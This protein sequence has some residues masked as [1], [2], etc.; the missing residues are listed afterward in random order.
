MSTT[1]SPLNITEMAAGELYPHSTFNAAMAILNRGGRVDEAVANE[2]SI[3]TTATLDATAFGKTHIITGTSADYT[4]TLFT[5]VT[6]DLGKIIGFRVSNAATKVFTIDA[7]GAETIDGSTSL[8]LVKNEVVYLKAV[9]TTGNTWQVIGRNTSSAIVWT[10]AWTNLT[11]GNGTVV[12]SF[13]KIGK[14]V[15]CRVSIVFGTTT[16]VSGDIQFSLPITRAAYAGAALL[17]P[18]GVARLYD[19]SGAIVLPGDVITVNT[20]TSAVRSHVVSGSNVVQGLCSA[21]APFTWATTD[22][23]IAQFHFE[24]A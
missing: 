13:I 16:V 8:T 14:L 5:P 10:P 7:A 22:E 18:L 24:A 2:V 1:G 4:I 21:T 6:A 19:A 23:I 20:T 17:T 11:V 12:A 3:T 15:F 9:S